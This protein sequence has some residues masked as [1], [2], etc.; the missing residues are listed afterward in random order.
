M[1]IYQ[2]SPS[3]TSE[4]NY[5]RRRLSAVERRTL[6]TLTYSTTTNQTV[7]T[8]TSVWSDTVVVPDQGILEFACNLLIT[9]S[10]AAAAYFTFYIDNT[11]ATQ[12]AYRNAAG[13]GSLRLST[14]QGDPN[15]SQGSGNP[16]GFII[17]TSV[18]PNGTGSGWN[19]DPGEHTV[20]V[21]CN[22][23]T[24]TGT[25]TVTDFTIAVRTS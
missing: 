14:L 9:T 22:S 19:I 3:L 12:F 20:E 25:V 6:G 17:P 15:G 24:G 4:F 8:G 10:G 13:A 16:G 18:A 21:K 2:R 23:K 1:A 7:T 11:A 5:M